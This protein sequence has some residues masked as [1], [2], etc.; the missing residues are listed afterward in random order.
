MEKY[1]RTFAMASKNS[2]QTYRPGCANSRQHNI[3]SGRHVKWWDTASIL[4][5]EVRWTFFGTALIAKA[6]NFFA[7]LFDSCNFMLYWNAYITC[8]S[9]KLWI[10]GSRVKQVSKLMTSITLIRKH[11]MAE[12]S[13]DERQKYFPLAALTRIPSEVP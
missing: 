6:V 11:N 1:S 8:T 4:I 7:S 3:L 9:A 13:F 10:N 5:F 12:S 2:L